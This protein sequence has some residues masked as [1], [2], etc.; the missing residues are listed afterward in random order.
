MTSIFQ[1]G[2]PFN[3]VR[4]SST[5]YQANDK[6]LVISSGDEVALPSPNQGAAILVRPA[7]SI[8]SVKITTSNG[9]IGNTG[10]TFGIYRATEPIYLVGDGTDWY[11]R[12]GGGEISAIPDSGL[13]HKFGF[14]Q[15]LDDDV[16]NKSLTASDDTAYSTTAVE[17][18]HALNPDGSNDQY[19]TTIDLQN[20]SAD[21]EWSVVAPFRKSSYSGTDGVWSQT[22]DDGDFRASIRTNGDTLEFVMYDTNTDS[23]IVSFNDALSTDQWHLAVLAWDGSSDFV[24]YV[25]SGNISKTGSPGSWQAEQNFTVASNGGGQYWPGL[26]DATLVYDRQITASDVDGIADAFGI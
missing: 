2:Q 4:T 7:P 5:T 6:D 13:V 26:I 8:D 17:G 18:S 19:Q 22:K 12:S 9:T 3:V 10:E 11:A 16:G 25:D 20:L 23:T 21:N 15:S 14:N 24:A 1:A